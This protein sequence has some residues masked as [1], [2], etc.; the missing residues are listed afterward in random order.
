MNKQAVVSSECRRRPKRFTVLSKAWRGN[1][2]GS[3]RTLPIL[4]PGL[5]AEVMLERGAA[6]SEEFSYTDK[7]FWEETF[8]RQLVVTA[9]LSW[10]TELHVFYLTVIQ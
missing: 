6:C 5:K 10:L 7:D 4:L 9:K 3:E 8:L 1:K 2:E